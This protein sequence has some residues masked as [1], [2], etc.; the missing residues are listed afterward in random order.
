MTV[1][2]STP[3]ADHLTPAAV[4]FWAGIRTVASLDLRQRWR[5][6]RTRWVLLTWI[7]AV[8]GFVGLTWLATHQMT[9]QSQ[10]SVF[11]GV[12]M[13]VV[14]TL[15]LLVA[16]SLSASAISGDRADGVLVSLQVTLLSP[17]QIVLGKFL[18]AWAAALGFLAIAA[19]VLLWALLAGGVS[20]GTLLVALLSLILITGT[21][22]ALGLAISALTARVVSSTTLTYVV[23]GFLVIGIPLLF[24][25]TLPLTQSTESYR[26][27]RH[28]ASN[29]R[30]SNWRPAPGTTEPPPCVEATELRTMVHTE[31]TWWLLAAN[32][33]VLVADAAPGAR[34]LRAGTSEPLGIIR[35]GV[36]I[37]RRG[38]TEP[39]VE[40]WTGTGTPIE[41][42]RSSDDSARRL[43]DP[44][45]P[46]GVTTY[47]L[48]GAG[49]LAIA[50]RRLRTP[51]HK[52]PRGTRI[53]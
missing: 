48:L 50:T 15:A 28:D 4:P 37:A 42:P 1:Q 24:G 2:M 27:L 35:E 31:R 16:P 8:Y 10:A 26:V 25:L 20:L 52:L 3:R 44:V 43:D 5:A 11:Y 9:I 14:L 47:A 7:V 34:S 19:P 12:T 17:A 18:A 53:A 32:P 21:V 30:P 38:A 40:C 6:A 46:F 39:I 13:F 51:C 29:W 45:W 41:D 23:L 33:F 36:R 49:A 22:C